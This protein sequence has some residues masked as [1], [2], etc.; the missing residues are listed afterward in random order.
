MTDVS[1]NEN[2]HFLVQIWCFYNFGTAYKTKKFHL[3][4]TDLRKWKVGMEWSILMNTCGI[5]A[6]VVVIEW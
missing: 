3:N 4:R 5:G 1:S 2:T 6:V